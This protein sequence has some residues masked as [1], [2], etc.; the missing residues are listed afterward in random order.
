[1]T[2]TL[3]VRTAPWRA[4][5]AQLASAVDGLVPVV[6][7]NGYGFGR[8]ALA[9][10]AAEFCDTVAVGTVH[11]LD[12]LPDDL[13]A[14]V[15]TPT[16]APP[17]STAPILTVG[18]HAHIEA[19]NGWHGR[20]LVKLESSMHRYGGGTDLVDA[21][22]ACGLDVIG[23]S[24]HLPLAGSHHDHADE[25]RR[26]ITDVDPDLTVWL[27]HLDPPTYASLPTTHAYRLRLGTSLW[28][29]DKSFLS[30][31]ADVLDVRPIR[32]GARAGY[33]QAAVVGNGH[34]V[35]I[36]AG[37][38]NGVTTLA[39]GRSPFHF[40]RRRLPLHEAPHMHTAMAFVPDG[41]TVPDVGRRVDVQRPLT[42][43]TVDT[44]EWI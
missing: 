13:H 25:I 21:A 18:S 33:H 37:T 17:D 19:L 10:L 7:G 34:L 3:T 36:G 27:S 41:G 26:T 38:A 6:K 39:D 11:E 16:L 29:G 23:V 1:V 44:I 5:V 30:L 15:L 24:L 2:I 14:V 4:Q 12:G 8:L 42:M 20:V 43:T 35:M 32:A 31:S 9:R 28:H 40:E 22:R